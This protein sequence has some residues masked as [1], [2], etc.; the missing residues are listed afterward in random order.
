MEH[1]TRQERLVLV[2]FAVITLAGLA[3]FFGTYWDDAWHTDFGR[4]DFFIPPHLVLYAGIT[5]MGAVATRALAAWLRTRS[6]RAVWANPALRLGLLGV[7][8]TLL[9]APVDEVWHVAFGRDAVVWSPPHMLG[10]AALFALATG[11]FLEAA[12]LPGR[13]GAVLT[14]AMGAFLIGAVHVPVMEYE[15]D[16]PQFAVLWYLPVLTAGTALAFAIIET[17]RR[18]VWTITAAAMTWTGIRIGIVGFLAALD[19]SLIFVPPIVLPAL[20]FELTGRLRWS[21]PT[22]AATHAAVMFVVYVPFLNIAL[23]G[24][25]LG[26]ADVVVG[27]PLAAG[28]AWLALAGFGGAVPRPR[29]AHVAPVLV[30][31]ALIP[32][33]ARAHDPGQGTVVGTARLEASPVGETIRLDVQVLANGHGSCDRF[34]PVRLVARRA[35]VTLSG[36]VVRTGECGS[37]GSVELPGRGRWFVYA[38]MTMAGRPVEAWLPVMAGDVEATIRDADIFVPPARAGTFSL[39]QVLSGVLLYALCVGFLWTAVR[40]ARRSEDADDDGG[41]A[42][43][44]AGPVNHRRGR[45]AV[46]TSTLVLALASATAASGQEAAPVDSNAT[47]PTRAERRHVI[48]PRPLVFHDTETGW[49]AGVDIF[50][51]YRPHGSDRPPSMNHLYGVYT[52]TGMAMAMLSTAIHTEGDLYRIGGHAT[53]VYY[54]QTFYGIG[55][56]LPMDGGEAY[57]SRSAALDLSVRRRFGPR[58]VLGAGWS[59]ERY[60]LLERDPSGRLADGSITGSD[61]GVVSSVSIQAGLDTREGLPSA[62]RGS[63]LVV[64]GRGADPVLGSDF[65]FA[66][67]R[68]DARHFTPLPAGQVLGLH[69]ATAFTFGDAPFQSLP[70]MGGDDIMRGYSPAFH[71]DRHTAAAQAEYR[72]PVWWRFGAVGFAGAGAVAPDLAGFDRDAVR[73][74]YGGGLRFAINRAQRLNFRA[75][76]GMGSEGSRLHVSVGEAF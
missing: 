68:L 75:D 63:Y 35:G 6:V 53:Y 44:S 19:H 47:I 60:T 22:R 32:G 49:S 30:A 40:A 34:E 46:T 72:V 1:T 31:L 67:L 39:G 11:F 24:I 45:M 3:A 41:I 26:V 51:S 54:P 25:R 21:A 38:E 29:P 14:V 16:V 9:A 36:P 61:G 28:A 57:T 58:L 50:H 56:D 48:I 17:R 37:A 7:T 55:R 12:R 59:G 27:A 76:W 52:T 66:R 8:A 23:G 69:G 73:F 4:D 43:S 2:G 71:R 15:S 10:F 42:A 74:S 33:E 18:L 20:A 13:W 65:R 64:T 62:R 70:R 5:L